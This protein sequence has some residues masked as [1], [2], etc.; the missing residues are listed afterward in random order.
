[1][2]ASGLPWWQQR[3]RLSISSPDR[4]LRITLGPRGRG[5]RI[6]LDRSKGTRKSR[7]LGARGL[8][9][10]GFPGGQTC[11]LAPPGSLLVQ[12]LSDLLLALASG[13]DVLCSGA[14]GPGS[15][16]GT[17]GRFRLPRAEAGGYRRRGPASRSPP[18]FSWAGPWG[19]WR[20]GGPGGQ[21]P[22]PPS[23]GPG[24]KKSGRGALSAPGLEPN[25]DRTPPAAFFWGDIRWRASPPGM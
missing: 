11:A 9:R 23:R 3:R 16:L 21:A 18:L 20:P 8:V 13:H 7:V 10:R 12:S 1:M 24:A 17:P 2:R 22:A 19:R 25:R 15:P 4:T 5:L 14:L 6:R